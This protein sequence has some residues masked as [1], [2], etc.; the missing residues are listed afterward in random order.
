MNASR[1]L[2]IAA[3]FFSGPGLAAVLTRAG[4]ENLSDGAPESLET[5]TELRD[6]FDEVHMAHDS[7]KKSPHKLLAKISSQPEP[8]A[9]ATV[10]TGEVIRIEVPRVDGEN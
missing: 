3:V 8:A 7:L 1:S 9:L 10:N 2:S 4:D 6:H 5:I